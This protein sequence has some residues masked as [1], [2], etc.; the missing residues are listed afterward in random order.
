MIGAPGIPRTFLPDYRFCAKV[1]KSHAENF[2]VASAFL[3]PRLRHHLAAVYAFARTADDFADQP[4]REEAE[5]LRLLD[6]WEK[7]LD[8]AVE[9]QADHPIFR[10]LTCTLSNT[11]LTADPLKDLLK[12]FR[13]DVTKKRYADNAELEAY[14]RLSANPVGRI[15]L[16]LAGEATEENL[17]HSD[18]ICTALQLINH[19]QDLGRDS[20]AGR[21]LYLPQ[22]EMD[23]FEVSEQN[24]LARR[25]TPGMGELMLHLVERERGLLDMGEPLIDALSGMLK[26]EIAITWEA[27]VKLLEKIEDQG[28][29]T[30]RHRP[31]L[32]KGDFFACFLKAVRR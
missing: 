13:Q 27:G 18:A 9:G 19:W 11:E 22:E 32:A 25:F 21:P 4:G 30:L 24:V 15:V 23:H 7:K 31:R 28:G 14:C 26:L 2:P 17:G 16:T 3:P 1:V 8:N 10:A 12:A 29:D 6:D 5:R 20:A